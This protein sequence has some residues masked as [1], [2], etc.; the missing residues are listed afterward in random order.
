MSIRHVFSASAAAVLMLAMTA[1]TSAAGQAAGQADST[2]DAQ[3]TLVGCVQREAD[4]RK[5]HQSGR[6]GPVST[7]VGL[8][9]EYVLVSAATAGT[10]TA[11]PTCTGSGT[12]EAYELTG[13]R[14]GEL[15]SYVGRAVEITGTMKNAK[16][17]VSGKPTGGFDPLGQDLELREVN[18]AS[19]REA[20]APRA[21]AAAEPAPAPEAVV[22]QAS[23]EPQQVGTAGAQ[24]ELPRTAGPLPLTGLIGLLSFAGALGVRSLRRRQ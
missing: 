7:G 15:E 5:E 16:L 3:I 21:E 9:N 4:Y 23:P 8:K 22:A 1:P 6:G 2:S 14:E 12:G 17:D 13:S 24:Q 19:F 20:A 11:M 10:T 18:I